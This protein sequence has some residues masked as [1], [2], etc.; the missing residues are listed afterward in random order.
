MPSWSI[1]ISLLQTLDILTFGLLKHQTHGLWFGN[2]L[3]ILTILHGQIHFLVFFSLWRLTI[4]LGSWPYSS[5]FKASTG[6]SFSNCIPLPSAYVITPP[7]FTKTLIITLDHQIIQDYL[8]FSP[9]LI[10][11][12]KSIVLC[13]V[14]RFHGLGD[15]YLEVCM[16]VWG[17]GAF[18]CLPYTLIFLTRTF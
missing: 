8:P 14:S 18:S 11:S 16:C 9:F 12:A 4:F 7:Q 5:I 10:R 6:R 3:N 13:N 2:N 15:G 17:G 1:N